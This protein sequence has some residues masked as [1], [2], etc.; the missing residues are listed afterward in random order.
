MNETEFAPLTTTREQRGLVLAATS[1]I[2][3]KGALWVV[4]SA[5]SEKNYEVCLIKDGPICTCPDHETRGG[6]CKHIIAVEIVVKRERD[7]T[8]AVTETRQ[9]TVTETRKTYPQ[10]WAA[11]NKA[12]TNE[13]HQFTALLR[14]LCDLIP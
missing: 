4:P 9:V 2:T 6:R 11:Y 1:K 13:K 7:E 14:S 8:G 12:Q 5:T 3:R 10:N